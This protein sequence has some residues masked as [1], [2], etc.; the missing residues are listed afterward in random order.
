[1]CS[2]YNKIEIRTLPT[3]NPWLDID[4]TTVD[5]LV[6]NTIIVESP[7]TQKHRVWASIRRFP[8]LDLLTTSSDAASTS[9][10]ETV[11]V[12][13]PQELLTEYRGITSSKPG[14]QMAYIPYSGNAVRKQV[15]TANVLHQQ[16]RVDS[17]PETIQHD[18]GI[19]AL[20]ATLE[21]MNPVSEDGFSAFAPSAHKFEAVQ[22]SSSG[23]PHEGQYAAYRLA[24]NPLVPPPLRI[25]HEEPDSPSA[26]YIHDL[27]RNW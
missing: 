4:D 3:S 5:N 2:I 24:N 10:S 14:S 6:P 17:F 21:F 7:T 19:P 25:R 1:M 12:H 13:E 15:A 22:K 20:T 18:Q 11:S 23:H 8:S 27:C 26:Q 16:K 9:S